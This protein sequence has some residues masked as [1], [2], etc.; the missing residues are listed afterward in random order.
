MFTELI[1]NKYLIL[2]KKLVKLDNW[3]EKSHVG[4]K[5][6]VRWSMKRRRIFMNLKKK[7]AVFMSLSSLLNTVTAKG[8]D[9]INYN[10]NRDY[11][12]DFDQQDNEENDE[13]DKFIN[14]FNLEPIDYLSELTKLDLVTALS[15]LFTVVGAYKKICDNSITVPKQL[16][17]EKENREAAPIPTEV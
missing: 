7:L 8:V 4:E 2:T 3:E 5:W 1:L 17:K 6:G 13:Y 10:F 15:A 12:N 9:T 11:I 16:P 14:N